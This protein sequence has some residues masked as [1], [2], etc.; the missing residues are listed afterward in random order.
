MLMYSHSLTVW[1]SCSANGE[2]VALNRIA[3]GI[4]SKVFT[5]LCCLQSELGSNSWVQ[6]MFLQVRSHRCLPSGTQ[7]IPCFCFF[8][9]FYPKVHH[10]SAAHL[11]IW[12]GKDPFAQMQGECVSLKLI[13]P[14]KCS[15]DWT[16]C[17][18]MTLKSISIQVLLLFH[19]LLQTNS[20][21]NSWHNDSGSS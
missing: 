11:I 12:Q 3:L 19:L 16:L 21:N 8:F 4:P 7:I 5:L 18:K 9:C 20:S 14:C 17:V 6:N 10:I 1:A 15:P 2:M 13:R